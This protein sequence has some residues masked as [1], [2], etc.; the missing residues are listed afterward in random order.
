MRFTVS[1]DSAAVTKVNPETIEEREISIVGKTITEPTK[2][3]I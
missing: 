3:E 1:P 2:V